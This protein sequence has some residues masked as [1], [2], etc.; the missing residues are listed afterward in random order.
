MAEA[1]QNASSRRVVGEQGRGLEPGQVDDPCE[2]DLGASEEF[3]ESD[4]VVAVLL[5]PSRD[6]TPGV[7]EEKVGEPRR[8]ES[9]T[10][11]RQERLDLAPAFADERPGKLLD[12]AEWESQGLGRREPEASGDPGRVVGEA[13]PEVGV[14][15]EP[16]QQALGFA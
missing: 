3:G 14:G 5:D 6:V 2:G 9:P 7:A 12:L 1:G 13:R 15:A 11:Q 8:S 10:G 16:G 4:G